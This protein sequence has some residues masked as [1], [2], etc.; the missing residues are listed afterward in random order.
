MKIHETSIKRPVTVLMAVLIVMVLGFVSFT[1]IPIDLMPKIDIPVAIVSTSYSGVGPQEIETII[2]KN[3]EGAVASVSNIKAIRSI[4]SSG[5][6][7][8]IA[9]FN[10]GTDM[11]FATLQMREKIDLVKRYLPDEVETPMVIKMDPNMIP[12]VSLGISNGVNAAELKKF[13]EDKVK[14]RFESLDGVASVRVTGGKTREI[15][16]DVDPEKISGYGTSFSQISTAL[17]TENLNQPGGTVEYGDKSLLVRS[18]GEFK[19]LDQIKNIPIVLPSGNVI[20]LKDVAEV[21]DDYK[22]TSSY[23]RMN[24]KDSIGVIVLKQTNS[25]TVKVVNLIKKE[26][27]KIQKEYPKVS[28]KLVFDQG[29]YIEKSIDNVTKNAV[30]GA[31]LAILILFIF[32]KNI[33]TTLIIGTAIPISIISTFVLVYFSG[34]TINLVSLGGL[35]LGVGMLVDNAI[36]VLE[37]IYRHRN[38][39]YSRVE[40]AIHGT[41]EVGAAIIASTLTTIAVFTPVFFAEGVAADIFKELALTVAFSL[42][43]SLVVALTFIPML[44]SK[45]LKLDKSNGESKNKL[46]SGILSIWTNIFNVIESLYRNILKWVLRHKIV[47]VLCVVVIFISSLAL[48]PLVGTEFFPAMDQG[49]FTVNIELPKGALLE[50]TNEVTKQVEQVLAE[51]EDMDKMF[52]GVGSSGTGMDLTGADSSKASINATLKSLKERTRSTAQIVD[53]IRKKVALIPG[54]DIKV[55]EVSSMMGGGMGSGSAVAINIAGPEL[56]K[57]DQISNY[58]QEVVRSVQGTRQVESSIAE[59]RPE[60]QIYVDRD[61][62]AYYGLGTAAVAGSIRTAIEGKVATRYK[63][64]GEEFDIRMQFPKESRQNFE[65]LKSIKIIAPSGVEIPLMDIARIE[66]K[67][68]PVSI[69]REDQQRYV[70]VTSDI[71][72][73]DAGSINKDIKAKLD[74]YSLPSGYSIK[75]GGQEEQ[76]QEA[77]ISLFQML[78]LAILLVYMIMASQFESLVQPLIIMFSLPLAFT[79]AALGLVITHRTLSVPAFIGVIMLAGIVVNNAIVLIDYINTLRKN[80]MERYEAILKAGPTRLRPILMTTL[81]TILALLPL[82]LGIGEGAES[83]APM[84]TVVIGGLLS[85][86]VLTLVIVPIIYTW[87]DEI[88]LR[89][90]S[91]K[92]KKAVENL[93]V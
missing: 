60:A 9:E 84:A 42:F 37:N 14:S 51:I 50:Q 1:K 21:K 92:K 56:E 4:S 47:T 80:G 16:I 40:A 81:T 41:K 27:E 58:V 31:I 61:K 76:M 46:L 49:Q 38:E 87:F 62:A 5:S 64:G 45:F 70:T 26:I 89:F 75:F 18:T 2:T 74:N 22:D 25:N 19:T 20:Y 72:G 86:T 63:V 15:K 59:G 24:Q 36:V 13:V 29:E 30:V 35:A 3:I 78:L 88:A 11:D 82:A 77:F 17:Q 55:S 52:V 6:S 83:Q 28:I 53:D 73:R 54:A 65:Q 48:I 66:I 90:K 32:L 93:V 8:V 57:L 68:G 71:F 69:E 34:I 12:V 23:T 39:G 43:A 85:S 91:R 10:S 7:L 67:E 44:S 79:G 33:R